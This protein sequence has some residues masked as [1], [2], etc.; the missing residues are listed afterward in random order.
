MQVTALTGR[1]AVI[2]GR[3][4]ITALGV[5]RNACDNEGCCM[6]S[7]E[8]Q[9]REPRPEPGRMLEDILATTQGTQR[10]RS[11]GRRGV[12][13]QGHGPP[14]GRSPKAGINTCRRGEEEA[15]PSGKRRG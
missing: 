2:S 8:E 13:G 1:W 11:A 3:C 15:W 14:S 5:R 9:G 12:G 10:P 4:Q 7:E 6:H